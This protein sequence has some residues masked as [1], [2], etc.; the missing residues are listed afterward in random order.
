MRLVVSKRIMERKT[1]EQRRVDLFENFSTFLQMNPTKGPSTRFHAISTL[2]SLLL[3]N[4]GTNQVV[5]S[6][7]FK[8]AR[9]KALEICQPVLIIDTS[10]SL[11]RR[12]ERGEQ[13][14]TLVT[15][16]GIQKSILCALPVHHECRGQ[17]WHAQCPTPCRNYATPV[18]KLYHICE[19]FIIS[20]FQ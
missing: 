15:R 19:H 12:L 7:L 18:T 9:K 4:S 20:L 14:F 8:F 6:S 5:P 11:I 1:M 13:F 10:Y 16:S 17:V 2:E 3:P